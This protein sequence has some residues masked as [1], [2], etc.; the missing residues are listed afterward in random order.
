MWRYH[1]S[2][3]SL[4]DDIGEVEFDSNPP[5]ALVA[6]NGES[7]ARSSKRVQDNLA[8]RRTHLDDAIE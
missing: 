3:E 1:V 8:W 2:Y 6:R 4:H 5:A 7:G